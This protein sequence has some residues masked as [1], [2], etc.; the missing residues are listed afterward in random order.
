VVALPGPRRVE[1]APEPSAARVAKNAPSAPAVPCADEH[2]S[3]HGARGGGPGKRPTRTAKK[4]CD[5][6][7]TID[8]AGHRRYKMECL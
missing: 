5:P 6:A 8:E 2:G 7:Y 4:N 3:A 1:P